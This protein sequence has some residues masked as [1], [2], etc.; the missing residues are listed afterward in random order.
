[1]TE[2]QWNLQRD[3]LTIDKRQN[4]T[5]TIKFQYPTEKYEYT[6]SPFLTLN[7]TSFYLYSTGTP[8]R[9][10]SRYKTKWIHAPTRITYLI[11]L[12][13]EKLLIISQSIYTYF[14]PSWLIINR[15]WLYLIYWNDPLLSY[16]TSRP[17]CLE[18]SDADICI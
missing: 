15:D 13:G 11:T 3:N 4:T 14:M 12:R 16:F 6:Y 17:P 9:V 5:T 1:M 2:C 18:T 7:L 10:Y 8:Y